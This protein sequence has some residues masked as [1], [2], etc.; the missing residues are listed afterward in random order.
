MLILLLV[1]LLF[2]LSTILLVNLPPSALS[3][4]L[5]LSLSFSLISTYLRIY[6][7]SFVSLLPCKLLYFLSFLCTFSCLSVFSILYLSQTTHS[8]SIS[9]THPPYIYSTRVALTLSNQIIKQRTRETDQRHRT[10]TLID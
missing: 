6:F 9:Y 5:F 8:L 2:P 10:C 3:L 4:S 1:S 7:P